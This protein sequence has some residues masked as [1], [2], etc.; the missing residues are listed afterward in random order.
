MQPRILDRNTS[1][2]RFPHCRIGFPALVLGFCALACLT[3]QAA[4]AQAQIGTAESCF[5]AGPAKLPAH[6]TAS[7]PPPPAALPVR[8]SRA[9]ASPKARRSKSSALR[10]TR[11]AEESALNRK[12]T[13]SENK[14]RGATLTAER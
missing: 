11:S 6:T 7:I 14:D 13:A 3:Q 8:T 10:P 2:S 12:G 4:P 5:D 9:S 1:L